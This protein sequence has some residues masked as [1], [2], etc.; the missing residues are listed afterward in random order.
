MAKVIMVVTMD[1]D[2]E[3]AEDFDP[4]EGDYQDS[5]RSNAHRAI[6]EALNDLV[7][8][9]LGPIGPGVHVWA[10]TTGAA[11]DIMER[12]YIKIRQEAVKN[13][14]D[15]LREQLEQGEDV[16]EINVEEIVSD[17]TQVSYA[18]KARVIL[19]GGDFIPDGYTLA[20]ESLREDVQQLFDPGDVIEELYGEDEEEEEDDDDY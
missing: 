18:R 12:T 13:A 2:D 16:E 17:W 20:S 10:D 6:E 19:G 9:G 14:E 11:I 7:G 4:S 1:V 15:A 3:V 5:K 8:E